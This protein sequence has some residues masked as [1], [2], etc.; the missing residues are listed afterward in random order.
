MESRL[1]SPVESRLAFAVC[2]RRGPSVAAGPLSLL[3]GLR[4]G[5]A[6]C[7][8]HSP[9]PLSEKPG[10]C[11]RQRGAFLV[12]DS[13]VTAVSGRLRGCTW[14]TARRT[15]PSPQPLQGPR[16][17]G[18]AGPSLPR[19]RGQEGGTSRPRRSGA[20]PAHR[21]LSPAAPGLPGEQRCEGRV[22]VQRATLLLPAHALRLPVSDGAVGRRGTARGP[23]VPPGRARGRGRGKGGHTTHAPGSH[24]RATRPHQPPCRGLVLG[25][26]LGPGRGRRSAVCSSRRGP[27]PHC[28]PARPGNHPE[29]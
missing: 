10:R 25:V 8:A 15:W 13:R 29:M 11:V 5:H 24:P 22:R 9:G 1:A 7:L 12:G 3:S 21:V 14:G 18:Q 28:E 20:L 19:F 16:L 26:G 23:G 4:P 17:L 6:L 2:L 27:R